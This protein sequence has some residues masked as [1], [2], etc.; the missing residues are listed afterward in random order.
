MFPD[1]GRFQL[2]HRFLSLYQSGSRSKTMLHVLC[3][4]TGFSLNRRL[5]QIEDLNCGRGIL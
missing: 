4:A 1:Q 5:V 3:G 2:Q